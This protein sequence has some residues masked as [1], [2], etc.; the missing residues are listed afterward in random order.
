[1]VRCAAMA[2]LDRRSFLLAGAAGVSAMA[3]GPGLAEESAAPAPRASPMPRPTSR[4]LVISSS[5]GTSAVNRAMELLQ[6]GADPVDAVVEGVTIVED[7]PNDASVGYGGLPNEQGVVELDASVMHGPSHKA[8]CVAGMQSIR[9]PARVALLVLRRTN[10]VL[11][12]G[13]G[14]KRFALEHGFREEDL[15]TESSR[16]AW[17][18]WR[19]S[20]SAADDR[21]NPEQHVDRDAIPLRSRDDIPFTDGTIHCAAVDAAGDIGACT[22][23]SG[24]SWKIPGRV[25]DSP[26]IGAGNF[27]DNLVGAAGATDRGEAVIKSCGAFQI[28]QHMER[29]DE[30]EEAC[31]KVLRW[32][33]NHTRRRMLLNDRGEPNFQVTL[34]ALRKDGA[35]GSASMRKGRQYVVHDGVEA[36]LLQC[37]YL[38]E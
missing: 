4:P 13:E 33:A 5:N 8:G 11:L 1:V 17:L 36:K 25:G 6:Q 3:A 32:I 37:A 20:L 10:H 12:V 21:L 22:S 18:R 7:D 38:F 27:V 34:Y 2:P 24:L 26:I 28:V 35:F 16:Q 31:L 23:T 14:A 19:E 30:P 29:G 15:L 9:N